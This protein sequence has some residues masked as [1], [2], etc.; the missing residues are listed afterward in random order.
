MKMA[1]M[2]AEVS[3][4]H[5]AEILGHVRHAGMQRC[6]QARVERQEIQPEKSVSHLKTKAQRDSSSLWRFWV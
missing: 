2:E 5:G 1:Y 3:L 6:H 4:Q